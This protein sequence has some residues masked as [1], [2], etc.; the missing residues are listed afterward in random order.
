M[1]KLICSALAGVMLFSA[2]P[3]MAADINITIDGEE[4][5]PKNALGEVVEPFIENGSTYLPVRAMGEAVGKE[6]SFD[7]ENYAVYIG[8]RPMASELHNN[9]FALVE[10]RIYTEDEVNLYP[11]FEGIKESEAVIKLAESTI[12]KSVIE[13]KYDEIIAPYVD[14][15]TYYEPIIGF[16][17][18]MYAAACAEVLVENYSLTEEDYAP[19]VTAQHILV[20]DKETA[21]TIIEKI[22]NGADFK[23]LIEEYNTDPGQSKDSSYTFTY[24]EMVEEFEEAAFELKEGEYTKEPIPTAYGYHIIKRL[25]LQKEAIDSDSLKVK[26]LTEQ[27]EQIE[28][29]GVLV[30]PEGYYGKIDNTSFTYDELKDF[31]AFLGY[32]PVAKYGF[33]IIKEYVA[34]KNIGNELGLLDEDS[35]ETFK[36]I[37]VMSGYDFSRFGDKANYFLELFAIEEILAQKSSNGE[38]PEEFNLLWMN[39][40]SS[41]EYEMYNE[42]RVFVDGKIIVPADV[43]NNY[44]SPK[45]INGTVYVPVRAIVEALGMQADWDNDARCVV[46]TK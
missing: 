23:L 17:R 2:V 24:G 29:K 20:N 11:D 8:T 39:K 40:K 10:G 38:L 19:Y 46:I 1:K 34:L 6:V 5:I 26:A 35:I 21:D 14:P 18:Y 41:V 28:I 4:F 31:S 45:N 3:C 22:K 36:M 44:V 27:L 7:A 43:N 33:E 30:K 13:S 9:P 16:E 42:L 37:I 25:P 32:A 15:Y 12:E